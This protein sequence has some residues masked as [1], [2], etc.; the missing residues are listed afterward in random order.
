MAF[1]AV[2]LALFIRIAFVVA[3]DGFWSVDGGAYLLSR[4]AV[5]GMER[6]ADFPRPPFAPGWLLVP[7]TQLLG[8]NAGIRAF[9]V[10]AGIPLLASV[11][12]LI[13]ADLPRGV[14]LVG[15]VLVAYD[16]MLAEMFAAGAL[17]MLGF[18][19][20]LLVMW[21]VWRL[22]QGRPW[23][24]GLAVA[25]GIPAIAFVNQ[26][27][28]GIAAY[29]LIAWTLAAAWEDLRRMMIRLAPFVIVGVGLAALALPYYLAVAPGSDLLRYPGPLLTFNHW[30]NSTS[31]LLV[32]GLPL[33][34]IV[35]WKGEGIVR[36]IGMTLLTTSLLMPLY[37]YDETVMNVLYRSRYVQSMMIGLLV[38]W[39]AWK[40]LLVGWWKPYAAAWLGMLGIFVFAGYVYQL[41]TEAILARM[42]APETERAI[43][44]LD[45][46]DVDSRVATNSYSLS[47]YVSGLLEVPVSWSQ[48]YEPPPLYAQQH[49]DTVCLFG[50]TVCDP[51]EAAK[52][53]GVEYILVD[54]VWPSYGRE[55][56]HVPGLGSAYR[57]VQAA[58]LVVDTSL[59]EI[60]DVPEDVDDPWT[61]TE[62]APW[63][64]TV[65]E[66]GRTVVWRVNPEG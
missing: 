44:W 53:L 8:D 47:L 1:A 10:V 61:I 27:S 9:H 37:S 57:T 33:G 60:W 59:G 64:E 28:S 50:W 35:T 29:V 2:C 24:Y 51:D 11:W 46:Q 65:W 58:S 42:V 56:S 3:H 4:N 39:A 31:F 41:H 30:T 54:R 49:E 22:A 66:D 17:P 18:A 36:P 5:L 40:W 48:V 6:L 12:L 62:R 55:V 20:M 63:L 38:P 43:V 7:F 14:A 45:E 26:T 23:W 16:W 32:L 15:I 19:A 34:G 52:R 21:G 25:G 13:R